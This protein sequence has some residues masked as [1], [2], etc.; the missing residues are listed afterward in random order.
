MYPGKEREETEPRGDSEGI[1]TL[2]EN[3]YGLLGTIQQDEDS[4]EILSL[5]NRQLYEVLV[6]ISNEGP[7]SC[8]GK[9]NSRGLVSVR[10]AR[11][12]RQITSHPY[13]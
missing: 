11:K 9:G 5:P 4:G 6:G 3:L 13:G 8:H 12:G 7:G 1:K 2:E 10:R